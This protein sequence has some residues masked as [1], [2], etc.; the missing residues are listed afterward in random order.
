MKVSDET[1]QITEVESSE[2]SS[3]D[4]T[5]ACLTSKVPQE[6]QPAYAVSDVR[7]ISNNV[8]DATTKSVKVQFFKINIFSICKVLNIFLFTITLYKIF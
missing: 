8:E 4:D 5:R 3:S 2:P 6:S 7:E 1:P